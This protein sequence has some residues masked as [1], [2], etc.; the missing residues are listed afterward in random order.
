MKRTMKRKTSKSF[1]WLRPADCGFAGRAP[2]V[3]R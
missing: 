3:S 1:A 2:K